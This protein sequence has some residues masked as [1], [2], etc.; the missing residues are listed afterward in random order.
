M[1]H[2]KLAAVI[3]AGGKTTALARLAGLH[4][5]ERVL[6]T[7]T[8]HIF[9]FSPPVCD[10]LCISPTAAVLAQALR[11]PGV[12]CAGVG[13]AGGKLTGLSGPEMQAALAQA[14]WIFYEA[15][16]AKRLPLKLHAGHEPVMLPGTAHCFVVAGLSALGAPICRAVHRYDL[17]AEWARDP[18]RPVDGSVIAACVDDA[19]RACGLPQTR[20]TVLL[21]QADVPAD[22]RAVQSLAESLKRAGLRCVVC[23]LQGDRDLAEA[24]AF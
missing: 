3:G 4:R 24:P 7:T 20:L 16:G 13:S 14:D 23:S 6:L 2:A 12:V 8:T 5:A 15:D 1:Q 9:P 19:V 21:N 11:S 18:W 17:R 22:G 10:R